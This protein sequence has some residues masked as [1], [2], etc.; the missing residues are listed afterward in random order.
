MLYPHV[1]YLGPAHPDA[2]DHATMRELDS[3]A[4]SYPHAGDLRRR[5]PGTRAVTDRSDG[6]AGARP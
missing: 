4:D 6:L 5:E 1:T 3:R 2:S